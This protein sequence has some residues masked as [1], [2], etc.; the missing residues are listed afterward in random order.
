MIVSP[1]CPI[2]RDDDGQLVPMSR[3]T[4][5]QTGT[6]TDKGDG[7]NTNKDSDTDHRED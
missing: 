3:H 7:Q 2:F 1:G 5:G 4:D 6:V